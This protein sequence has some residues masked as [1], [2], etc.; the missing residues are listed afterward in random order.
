MMAIWGAPLDDARNAEHAIQCD[1]EMADM[2]EA[3]RKELDAD[4]DVDLGIGIHSGPAV[5][6]LIGAEQRREYGA[7]GD[8]VNLGSHIAALAN[9][10]ARI[11]VSEQAMRLCPEAFD[12]VPRGLYKVKSRSSEIALY[13]PKRKTA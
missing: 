2:L 12:F 4:A 1:L 3:F 9:G 11:L 10:I 6:G 8:T 13:E 7:I 5:V